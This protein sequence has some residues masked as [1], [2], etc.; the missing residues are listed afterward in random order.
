[1][2]VSTQILRYIK[3]QAKAEIIR[4]VAQPVFKN[5]NKNDGIIYA[6]ITIDTEQDFSK[7]YT[8]AGTYHSIEVGIPKLLSIF[9]NYNCKASWMVTPDVAINYPDIL[10]ELSNEKHEIGCHVHPEYFTEPSIAHIRHKVYLCNMPMD[11]QR[12]MIRGATDIIEKSVGKRPRS[13]RAGRYGIDNKTLNVLKSE[14]YSVDT[15]ISPNVSWSG[16]EGPDWSKFNSTQ[17]YFQDTLLEVPITV[18]KVMR[19]NY[20]LRPSV[21]T[22]LMMKAIVETLIS[23]QRGDIVLNMMFHSMESID[24][25]PYLK[26]E[27]FLRR[28]RDF[29]GYLCSKNI[30]FVT[31]DQLYEIRK[32]RTGVQ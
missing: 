21:S 27:V 15:S 16:D 31:L 13:F 25:N 11:I 7:G 20:W 22:V 12:D 1:L 17:P 10:K 18:I 4:L 19:L 28:L 2:E 6:V 8:N 14:G 23:Q 29:L 30:E 3:V 5:S 9:D 24:P 32:R 26:S